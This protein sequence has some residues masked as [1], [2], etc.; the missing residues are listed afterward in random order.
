MATQEVN[1]IRLKQA[2]KKFGSLQ[3]AIN[4]LQ[5]RKKSLETDVSVLI[6]DVDEKKK[7]RAKYLDDITHLEESVEERKRNLS[8]LEKAYKKSRQDFEAFIESIRQFLLQYQMF[9]DFVVML[10]TSPSNRESIRELA[11][12][13]VVI[14]EA[15]WSF[16]DT[17]GKL[18]WLFVQL[19]LGDH[20]HC[21]RCDRC[22]IK[23]IANKK[24]QSGILGYQCPNCRIISSVNPDDSFIEAMLGSSKPAHATQK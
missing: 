17:P 5:A 8:D 18:R 16:S 21:Y 23:F 10:Q 13:I 11:S 12:Y 24:P 6:K 4:S 9:E 7:A 20:L 1:G 19:V 3:K 14:G 22:G 15:V 2:I